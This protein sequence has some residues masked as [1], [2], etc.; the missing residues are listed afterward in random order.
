MS[1]SKSE[2]LLISK[3]LKLASGQFSNHG[4]NDLKI[5]NNEE[6]KQILCSMLIYNKDYDA[7]EIEEILSKQGPLYTNDSVIMSY[8][9]SR[10]QEEAK[11]E[12]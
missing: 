6:N 8:F 9:A 4:C 1:L 3:L 10:C 7:N 2:L 12:S 5:D 11:N